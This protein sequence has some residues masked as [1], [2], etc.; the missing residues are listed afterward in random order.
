VFTEA[1]FSR[2]DAPITAYD[3]SKTVA[4]LAAWDFVRFGTLFPAEVGSLYTRVGGRATSA[5]S[6]CPGSS[7][8]MSLT[9]RFVSTAPS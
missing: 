6:T 4:E 7:R 1:D 2:L 9:S 8:V 3:K 5:A